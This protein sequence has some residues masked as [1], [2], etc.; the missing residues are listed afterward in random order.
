MGRPDRNRSTSPLVN[1]SKVN[2]TKRPA[3]SGVH[4]S[5]PRLPR[6]SAASV[7][8]EIASIRYGLGYRPVSEDTQ[9]VGQ[10]IPSYLPLAPAT[11]D[12][13]PSRRIA[14]Q[15]LGSKV[16]D[17]TRAPICIFGDSQAFNPDLSLWKC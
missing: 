16:V 7:L 14:S 12:V 3:L 17:S 2:E 11:T 8:K 9:L 1:A 4:R 5:L 6:F 15:A 10:G 13:L